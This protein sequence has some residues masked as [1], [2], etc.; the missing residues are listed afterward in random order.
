M[1]RIF[2]SALLE[3]QATKASKSGH[4]EL[5]QHLAKRSKRLLD[6]ECEAQVRAEKK[7]ELKAKMK[8]ELDAL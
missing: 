5:A 2:R 8:A 6:E 1:F 4:V 7:A 3:A